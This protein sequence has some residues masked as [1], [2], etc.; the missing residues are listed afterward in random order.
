MNYDR[1]IS[2]FKFAMLRCM[3]FYGEVLLRVPII[4]N[5]QVRT[6]CTNGRVIEYSPLF[7]MRLSPAERNFV[8]MHEVMHII[9]RHYV[10]C[11]KRNAVLWNTAADII[12]NNTLKEMTSQLNKSGINF[13]CPDSAVTGQV[14]SSDT[15]EKIY[16][17]LCRRND[18]SNN[19]PSKIKIKT[20][21]NREQETAPP[22]DII[23]TEVLSGTAAE[24]LGDGEMRALLKNLH[25]KYRGASGSSYLPFEI[26]GALQGKRV[27][28][29]RLLRDF[30]VQEA[31]DESSYLTPERKY[32]HMDLII[33]GLG[34][35]N[36]KIEEIW[37]FVD[38]SG[39][40]SV[41][42]MRE[43]LF[44]LRS[45]TRQFKCVMNICYWDTK[46]NDV[47]KNITKD[48][49]IEK[50]L[51]NHSG[52][53]DINCVYGWLR[54][55]RVKPNLMLILTDGAFGCLNDAV[56]I[57]ALKQKTILVINN[58]SVYSDDFKRIGKT[59]RI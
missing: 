45:I 44:Q 31:G 25:N 11:G 24:G 21:W 9:L 2:G 59:A 14:F 43:F 39:S 40:V 1:E 46:I 37:A 51:P 19:K 26:S 50:C 54:E 32:L 33:P 12:V 7:F 6:A 5:R 28:W 23:E 38:C 53:T 56:F 47:Y 20:G 42:E 27:R 29:D 34:T 58:E 52:G 8:I 36:E 16:A 4:A 15:T 35:R 3:P 18:E 49:E 48:E 55:N 10:R 22:S 30:M 57:P 17:D 41:E 13:K